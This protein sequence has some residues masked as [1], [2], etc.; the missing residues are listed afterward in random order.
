ML[1]HNDTALEDSFRIRDSLESSGPRRGTGSRSQ[2]PPGEEQHRRLRWASKDH[3]R[4][5][6]QSDVDP[7]LKMSFQSPGLQNSLSS[8]DFAL[9]PAWLTPSY[10]LHHRP[11]PPYP[12]LSTPALRICLQT[13]YSNLLSHRRILTKPKPGR[14]RGRFLSSR[15]LSPQ[16]RKR[17]VGNFLDN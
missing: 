6:T 13:L 4:N 8:I 9:I 3:W 11:V 15:P 16:A 14:W 12:A 10:S 5:L 2:L 7:T 1:S 17:W